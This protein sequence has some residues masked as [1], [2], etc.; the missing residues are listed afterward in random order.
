MLALGCFASWSVILEGSQP[1]WEKFI[2][3]AHV[4][5]CMKF[6]YY[7][8]LGLIINSKFLVTI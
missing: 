4:Y 3:T 2:K 5:L 1:K 8:D 6:V 7:R